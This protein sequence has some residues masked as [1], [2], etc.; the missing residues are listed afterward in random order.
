[1]H[2]KFLPND[3]LLPWW[4]GKIAMVQYDKKTYSGLRISNHVCMV[5]NIPGACHPYFIQASV[6]TSVKK[7]CHYIVTD[8][9]E[10]NLLYTRGGTH[11]NR[12]I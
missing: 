1:M 6:K 12:T 3:L 7:I 2:C 11:S 4:Q 5:H 8:Y 9:V 10:N